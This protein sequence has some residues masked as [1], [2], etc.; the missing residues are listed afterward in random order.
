MRYFI[1]TEFIENGSTITL[2]SIGIVAEDGREFYAISTEFDP[3]K[4]SAWVK[5]NVLNHLPPRHVDPIYDSPRLRE[6]SKAWM[7]LK[8]IKQG[9]LDFIGD[10]KDIALWGDYCAFDFVAFSQLVSRQDN[11]YP[12]YTPWFLRKK[13]H[14]PMVAN[15][16]E[17]YPYFINDIQQY[18]QQVGA[19]KLLVL[20]E[21]SHHAL[22]DA[23]HIK[24]L[25]WFLRT[26]EED[27]VVERG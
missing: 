10:D 20:T 7:P 5:E 1:D 15:Y 22:Y 9:I 13:P 24:K 3:K 16:P 19:T 11:Q 12:W 26:Y 23:R 2:I 14:N 17:G 25:Y 27:C 21:G 4:A 8:D 18:R 6:E